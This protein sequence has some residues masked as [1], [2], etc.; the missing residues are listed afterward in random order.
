MNRKLLFT[1][2][3][4]LFGLATPALAESLTVYDGENY[5]SY[6]PIYGMWTDS[7]LKCEYVIPAS[8]LTEM[9][10]ATITSLTWYCSTKPTKAWG[11]NFQIFLKEISETTLSDFTGQN[12]ATLVFEGPLDATVDDF[13]IEFTQAFLYRY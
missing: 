1:L 13:I 8:D 6:A 5:N 9:N 4:M 10:G 12:G 2:V 3:M 7:Y 11:G